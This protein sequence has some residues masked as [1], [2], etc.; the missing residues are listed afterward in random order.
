MLRSVGLFGELQVL[1]EGFL[2]EPQFLSSAE[3]Q[4]LLDAIRPLEFHEVRMHGVIAR[5]RVIQYGWKYA[6]D[7]ARL[8]E[9]PPLPGFLL[10][11]RAR[12]AIFASVPA[13]A[14]SEA[15]ITEYPPGAPI[16]WHRDA[17]GFGIVVG[18]SLLS[19]CRFRFRRGP[20][21]GSERVTLTLEPGSAYVLSGPARTEW[22]HSI[23]EVETLRYSVTFRTLRKR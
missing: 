2:Y 6:F 21:R 18:I 5:R 23:P 7:G 13:D 4:S 12:A 15:L 1:P 19:A 22:Q 3:H 17:P 8:S 20:E 16:G 14:L 10:P 9:G 11:V